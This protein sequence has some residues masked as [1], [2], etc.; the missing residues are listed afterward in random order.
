MD[1]QEKCSLCGGE[2]QDVTSIAG[3]VRRLECENPTCA[4]RDRLALG[5][6]FGTPL[7]LALGVN[8][9]DVSGFTLEV[10]AGDAVRLTVRRNV[11][12][13]QGSA[14][15]TVIEQCG[16]RVPIGA[17][18]KVSAVDPVSAVDLSLQQSP[19]SGPSN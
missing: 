15:V 16:L 1:D 7:L 3:S 18:A 8:P 14:L 12:S 4:S 13:G 19:A 9:R 17:G 5:R 11:R 2:L 10:N 6:E